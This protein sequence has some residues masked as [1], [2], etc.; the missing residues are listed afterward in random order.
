[1]DYSDAI[2]FRSMVSVTIGEP[3]SV[4]EYKKSYLLNEF[5]GVSQLTE[6]IRQK[7][8]KHI[9]NT[10]NKEQEQFLL[11]A[12]KFYSTFNAPLT[13]L[14]LNPKESLLSRAQISKSLYFLYDN[15]HKLYTD[16][17]TKVHLFFD[18]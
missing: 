10:T 14:H 16:T 18:K 1:M 11:K 2:Q 15:N 9:P 7:L 8:Y 12:H 5:D 4:K 3:I 6:S 13:D 17:E